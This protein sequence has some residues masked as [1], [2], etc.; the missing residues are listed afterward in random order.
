MVR[1]TKQRKAAPPNWRNPGEFH[2]L[3]ENRIAQAIYS[4]KRS[5]SRPSV[6]S[7]PDLVGR[8]IE[9]RCTTGKLREYI[10]AVYNLREYTHADVRAVPN[11]PVERTV[12][13]YFEG[14]MLPSQTHQLLY[15]QML[16]L[17]VCDPD[18]AQR[19]AVFE[20]RS[21]S[22]VPPMQ[23]TYWRTHFHK[24]VDIKRMAIGEYSHL[25]T[26]TN[27]AVMIP[28]FSMQR[29][30]FDS[31]N[32]YESYTRGLLDFA[33]R[34]TEGVAKA[35]A[36]DSFIA[37]VFRTAQTTRSVFKM[38]AGFQALCRMFEIPDD[39]IAEAEKPSRAI[40]DHIDTAALRKHLPDWADS[41][42]DHRELLSSVATVHRT[43]RAESSAGNY[44]QTAEI[45]SVLYVGD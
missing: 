12:T 30:Y 13:P 24:G 23:T 19:F 28:A 20:V 8:F 29:E 31:D 39:I 25:N 9:S 41:W 44:H 16:P 14:N 36:A 15:A 22:F 4:Y 40:I 11:S 18:N 27:P 10:K 34:Y 33:D 43:M 1:R 2:S 38:F 17:V 21:E 7:A 32:E 6:L 5:F 3:L 35:R 42:L 45:E 26:V 37:H